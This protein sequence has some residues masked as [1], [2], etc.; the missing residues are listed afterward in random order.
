MYCTRLGM[1]TK[2]IGQAYQIALQDFHKTLLLM[3]ERLEVRL[4]YKLF[5]D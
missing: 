4:Q 2:E 1:F 5:D 3:S